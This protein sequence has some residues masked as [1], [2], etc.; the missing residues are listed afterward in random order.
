MSSN[1]SKPK[2]STSDGIGKIRSDNFFVKNHK[3]FENK[4]WGRRGSKSRA[5]A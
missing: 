2:A 3:E 1:C 4:G 5:H